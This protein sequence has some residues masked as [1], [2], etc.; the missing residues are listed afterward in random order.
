M[1]RQLPGDVTWGYRGGFM[2]SQARCQIQE[3]PATSFYCAWACAGYGSADFFCFFSRPYC[4]C[5][6]VQCVF[7]CFFFC[8]FSGYSLTICRKVF[9][10]RFRA[11]PK[12]HLMCSLAS[13]ACSCQLFSSI[14][15]ERVKSPVAIR[16]RVL[17]MFGLTHGHLNHL[18]STDEERFVFCPDPRKN[19]K[20]DRQQLLDFGVLY[21][22]S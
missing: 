19:E 11:A 21:L 6:E 7:C 10:F 22:L 15:A 1:L 9:V 17:V 4:G 20:Q 3:D 16:Q 13:F 18:R 5:L 12:Q 2:F 8:C 14:L